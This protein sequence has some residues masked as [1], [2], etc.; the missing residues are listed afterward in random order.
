MFAKMRSSNAELSYQIK[1]GLYQSNISLDLFISICAGRKR[2]R[3]KFNCFTRMINVFMKMDYNMHIYL[4]EIL[5]TICFHL[6]K[7]NL[8]GN[9]SN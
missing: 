5:N 4:M 1:H 9:Q 8:N 3:Y 6:R 2:D 7:E